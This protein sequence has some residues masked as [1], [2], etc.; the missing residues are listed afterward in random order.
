[1]SGAVAVALGSGEGRATIEALRLGAAAGTA[2]P[3]LGAVVT[4]LG[5]RGAGGD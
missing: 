5:L 2:L 1:V 3:L 4:A